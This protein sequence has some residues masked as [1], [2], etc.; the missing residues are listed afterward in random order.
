MGL[1]TAPVPTGL[2][3]TASPS[4]GRATRLGSS[5]RAGV[6]KVL[7]ILEKL[8]PIARRLGTVVRVYAALA[9]AAVVVIGLAVVLSGPVGWA[10][11]AAVTVLVAVLA[12]PVVLLW[13]F[14]RALDEAVALPERIRENPELMRGHAG[15]VAQ[16]VRESHARSR[17]GRWI[18][19]LPGD[20]WKAGRL[21]LDAHRDLPEYGHAIR[22]ISIPY[23]LLTAAAAV[24]ALVEM[25]LAPVV[26]LL[27]L[28]LA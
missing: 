4:P 12:A 1:V 26:V 9:G 14:A 7:P 20:I 15:E 21:L 25:F 11:W 23:L 16:L 18:V 8:V 3:P 13:I 24:M 5:A 2:S 19:G 17:Q 22:L 27:A 10:Q 6:D 28:L